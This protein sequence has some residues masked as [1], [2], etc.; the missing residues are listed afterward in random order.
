MW[1]AVSVILSTVLLIFLFGALKINIDRNLAEARVWQHGGVTA[2]PETGSADIPESC[3]VDDTFSSHLPILVI[4]TDGIPISGTGDGDSN[5][6]VS[7]TVTVYDSPDGANSLSSG[8]GE[9]YIGRIKLRGEHVADSSKYQYRIKFLDT[10][11]DARNV[12]LL[13]MTKADEWILDGSAADESNLRNYIGYSLAG[14]MGLNSP[15]VRYC[16]V[17]MRSGDDYE[18]MGLYLAVEPVE[19]GKG[20]VSFTGKRSLTGAYSYIVKRDGEDSSRPTLETWATANSV[21]VAI[22]RTDRLLT[23]VYPKNSKATEDAIRYVTEDLSEIERIIYSDSVLSEAALK[24]FLDV[25]SFVDYY[26]LNEF[27]MNRDAGKRSTYMYRDIGGKLTMGPVWGFNDSAGKKESQRCTIHTMPLFNRLVLNDF[28]TRRLEM[29][30]EELREEYLS[31][32]RILSVITETEAFLGN[33]LSRDNFR[34]QAFGATDVDFDE[35]AA[36]L[37]DRLTEHAG[38]LDSSLL[39]FDSGEE[40][41]SSP[42]LMA[43]DDD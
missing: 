31:D 41:V 18:Y 20:R 6:Y 21:D 5:P 24:E 3:H 35:A 1:I 17:L 25:D 14:E 39:L 7:M 30:W 12:S 9:T 8:S 37:C 26:L 4:D 29:R 36:R 15:D 34:R 33:A 19:Q 22:G 2:S 38:Y 40:D 13:G 27:M 11:G 16:E 32:E 42:F 28:F 23:L 10:F 43:A